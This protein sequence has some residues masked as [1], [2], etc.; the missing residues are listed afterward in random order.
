MAQG[1]K[2]L[3][4]IQ[5][6]REAVAG[7]AV[8][9][10]TIWRGM[11]TLEDQRETVFPPEDIGYLS[12]VNR[13]YQPK[14]GAALSMDS[15]EATYE[16]ICHVLEA[17]IKLV[18]TGAADGAGSG[19]IYAY[20]LPV[21]QANTTR[22]YTIEG[23]DNIA[24]EEMEYSFVSEFGL[25]G[26][27]GKAV[28]LSAT[29]YGRQ[30]STSAF[31]ASVALP[32]VEEMLFSK[33]VLYADSVSGTIGATTQSNTLL[34]ASIKVVTGL[35]PVYTAGGQLYYS[36]VKQTEPEVTLSITY[37]HDS[38]SIA[39]KAFYVAG[40]ARKLRLKI[41]GSTLTTAGT[42]YSTKALVVDLAGKW[43]N[44]SKIDEQDGNDIL[45]GTFRARY[46]ST[47]ALFASLTVVNVLTSLP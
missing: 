3:R 27:A 31:T 40:T 21:T 36:F 22:T 15:I 30:I 10:T 11:G 38:L 2:A 44:F 29:W 6:G 34:K 39:E 43:E 13:S 28:M 37:E 42:A 5:M 16:Q 7:T 12:G 46:D 1:I 32:T 41:L 35:I 4:K 23:G 47:A 18:Q 8:V 45:T 20:P 24:A 9:A 25:D 26:E 14:L 19:K 33:C 17:G